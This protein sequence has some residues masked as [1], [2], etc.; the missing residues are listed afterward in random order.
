[1]RASITLTLAT[2]LALT[3][4]SHVKAVGNNDDR[5]RGRGDSL[6]GTIQLGPRPYFLIDDDANTTADLPGYAE[7]VGYR[8]QGIRIWAPPTFALLTTDGSRILP[9]QAALDARAAGL[10][11][12]T[13]TL[14]RSGILADGNNG[15]YYQTVDTAIRREGD[16]M[17]VIDVLARGVGVR[18]IFSDWPAPVTYYANC[19]GL[20]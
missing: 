8:Q 19:M 7:L 1:M 13:W 11:I 9:S 5:S 14:E 18:G 10:D 20:K 2:L 12:I 6:D 16:L 4:A 3:T 17:R 15:F